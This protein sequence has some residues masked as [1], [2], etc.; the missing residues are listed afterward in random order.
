MEV[1]GKV[2]KPFGAGNEAI[3]HLY[4]GAYSV[5]NSGEPLWVRIDSLA[6]PL[7]IGSH[8]PHGA[9]GAVV[10][11]D[12]FDSPGR[13]RQLVGLDLMSGAIPAAADDGELYF[14]D[15]VGYR[16]LLGG[17]VEGIIS[18]YIDHPLNPLFAVEAVGREVLVPAVDDFIGRIDETHRTV[19]FELPEG[20]LEL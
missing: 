8:R 4:D 10:T 9:S 19:R 13:I 5:L 11:F 3:I 20:L 18:G 15:L 2:S 7:F 16:A 14:E 6:V 1:I 12:D 17:G